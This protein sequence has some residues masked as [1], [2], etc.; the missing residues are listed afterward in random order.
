RHADALDQIGCG[1]DTTRPLVVGRAADEACDVGA[2]GEGA[3]AF[4][5]QHDDAHVVVERLELRPERLDD[6]CVDRID[7]RVVE[8]DRLDQV[9]TC[10][11]ANIS[12]SSVFKNL[13]T[14]VF[15]ISVMNS[16]RS[17]SHHL[18]K[19]GARK[20]RSSSPVAVAPSRRTTAASGRSSH[21]ASGIAI[22]AASATAG[23]AIS[24]FSRSTDEI[25][26]PPDL[27][28]SLVRSVMRT[29]PS[30]SIA[31]TSPVRSQP[32]SVNLSSLGATRWYEP[33][34]NGPR[35]WI[36]PTLLPSHGASLPSSPRM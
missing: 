30:S 36:S 21:F 7:R 13:P 14:L 1:L 4:A 19:F 31:A 6:P 24:A 8:P 27:I 26:S 33:V 9:G 5:A 34:M 10:S 2:R 29:K 15:G 17:G 32:S 16:Y 22:T 28:R 12:R 20:S 25:H 18:A 3:F 11:L 35:T 23:C